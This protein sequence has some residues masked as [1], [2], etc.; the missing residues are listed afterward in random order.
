V[1]LGEADLS[2][3]GFVFAVRVSAGLG[4]ECRRGEGNRAT[5]AKARGLFGAEHD[6]CDGVAWSKAAALE[7]RRE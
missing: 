7:G 1:I 3:G 2:D 6:E 4:R 5:D